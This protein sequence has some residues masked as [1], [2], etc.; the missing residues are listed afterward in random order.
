MKKSGVD[1]YC[2]FIANELNETFPVAVTGEPDAMK[3]AIVLA[4]HYKDGDEMPEG[5]KIGD[6]KTEETTKEVIN[7]LLVSNERLVPLLVKAVQELTAKVT[8]LENA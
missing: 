2:S 8:A 3:D 4:T 7:P 1:R 6:I 5:K